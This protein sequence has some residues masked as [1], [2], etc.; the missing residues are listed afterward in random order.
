MERCNVIVTSIKLGIFS[1]F[2]EVRWITR[3]IKM[4]RKTVIFLTISSNSVH[5]GKKKKISRKNVVKL[6]KLF[7]KITIETR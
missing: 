2:A 3:E 5:V 1:N 4:R 7:L 6:R